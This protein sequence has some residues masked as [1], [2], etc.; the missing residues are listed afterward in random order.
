ME[1]S[2]RW[3]FVNF[4]C[5]DAVFV[6]LLCGVAVFRLAQCQSS[7]LALSIRMEYGRGEGEQESGKGWRKAMIRVKQVTV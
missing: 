1:L 7:S 6:N 5:G 2:R 4:F 3:C